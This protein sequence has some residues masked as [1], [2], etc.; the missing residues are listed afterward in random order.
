MDSLLATLFLRI[1][2]VRTRHH[3]VETD[4]QEC[5]KRIGILTASIKLRV[6][7]IFVRSTTF[8][9]SFD[10]RVKSV[11]TTTTDHSGRRSDG[12]G[13]DAHTLTVSGGSVV[14]AVDKF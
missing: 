3:H 5:F 14:V 1:F 11:T 6:F 10:H 4:G 7:S 2:I 8:D 13:A 9:Q 12:G